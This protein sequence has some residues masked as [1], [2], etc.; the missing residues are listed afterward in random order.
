MSVIQR[1]RDKGAWIVF[2]IIALAL[3]AFIL[4]DGV[5][6]GGSGFSN[7]TTIGKVN[8]E[9]IERADFEQKLLMYGKGQQ[10]E[11]LIG[12]L[13]NQ[14]VSTII[15]QQEFDKLGLAISSKELNDIIFGENS[16]LKREF[17]DPQTGIFDVEKAKQAFAQI[18]KSKNAEQQ[19]GIIEAYIQPA[20]L[21]ALNAKYQTMIQQSLYVPKWLAEKQVA[22]NNLVSS[23]SFVYAP[24]SSVSDSAI[25]VSDEEIINYAKKHSVQYERDEE[26]RTITYVS[27]DATASAADSNATIN[28]LSLLKSEFS[29]TSDLPAFFSK[30]A[31]EAPYYNSYVSKKEI[32]Q[33][34]IDSIVKLPVGGIYGPYV[35]GNNFVLAKV[36]ATKQ[37]PDS[38]KVRHILISTHQ[39]DPNTGV[40][41][42][43]REDSVARKIMD[44][45]E[46]SIKNGKNFDSVCLKYSEDGGSKVKGGVYDYFASARMV[47]AFNDFSFDKPVGSKGVIHTEYGFHYV[48]VLGQK[49]SGPGYKIAYLSK[50]IIVSNETDAAANSAASQFAGTSR[51]KKQF[52]D[53]AAKLNK[54]WAP[55]GEI[56]ENDFTIPGL[57]ESRQ[58]VRWIYEHNM[59]DVND[60]PIR[61]GDKYVV[62]IVTSVIKPGLPPA[63]T[64]RASVESLVRNEKKAKQLLDTKF[65][66]STLEQLASAAGTTV[67]KADTVLFSNPFIPG[68]GNDAKFT[69]AAFNAANKGKVTEAV[70]GTAG[71]FALR[72]DNIAARAN[73]TESIESVK[74]TLL[75]AQRMALY[76]GSDALR[77]TAIIKD[78]RSKFY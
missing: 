66:G 58:L 67:Q 36:V 64:L 78:Y 23:V 22:D 65:K 25:K 17:T 8:G 52:D 20:I 29:S 43:V 15:M 19:A 54:P 50:P 53:N 35:D 47:P 14:E 12:Q 3:I 46:A 34:Y 28:Q 32:K 49:G 26:A 44:T 37:I 42:R 5:R 69:G 75:Q 6:R 70:A 76:R 38:A 57:G 21:Q 11:Q 62:A 59:G 72:V 40:L 71:V 31:T 24:Y 9:K 55:S 16:P 74:Q 4:Q 30:N 10:R 56:K 51:N 77:K 33:K 39:Q 73:S 63:Q 2:A 68:V 41:V 27:F 1:I 45:V 60:Q 61:I 18:K 48:E 13:W 7:N